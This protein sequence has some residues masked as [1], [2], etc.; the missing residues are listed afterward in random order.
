MGKRTQRRTPNSAQTPHSKL[1]SRKGCRQAVR[2]RLAAG[3][4][5]QRR[6][7]PASDRLRQV[8]QEAALECPICLQTLLWPVLAECGHLFCLP[9]AEELSRHD[10]ACGMCRNFEPAY[11]PRVDRRFQHL[12]RRFLEQG[13]PEERLIFEQR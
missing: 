3:R 8:L 7:E 4:S 10:Y 1:L 13:P 11:E 5:G 2:A 9:C 12:V 6:E